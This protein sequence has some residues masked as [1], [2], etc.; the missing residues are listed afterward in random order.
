[1]NALGLEVTSVGNH[2]FDEGYQELQRMQNGG[3]IDDGPDGLNNQN[4][5]PDGS[6]AGANFQYLSA[7]VKYEGTDQTILPPYWIKNFNGAKIG[8]IGMTLKETPSIVTAA[9]VAGL[10]FTDEVATANALVPVLE[11]QGV[12]A[13]VVLIHQGGDPGEHHVHRCL[14]PRLHRR[15]AL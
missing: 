2:E 11:A 14:R 1:M 15:P 7:N 12:K 9:G 4:S 8:F 3:C 5:C 13:I 10:E 6:F